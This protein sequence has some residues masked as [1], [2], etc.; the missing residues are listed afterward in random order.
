MKKPQHT[1]AYF[2]FDDN[3]SQMLSDVLAFLTAISTAPGNT[4]VTIAAAA[5]AA[6]KTKITT[7]Q[8]AESNTKTRAI[9][10]AN[11]RDL[12]VEPVVI[13]VQNYVAV[14]QTAV[15]N[16]PNKATALTIIRE[17]G[18]HSKLPVII[19]KNDF[20]VTNNTTTNGMVNIV[21]KAAGEGIHA[22]YEIQE[23]IDGINFTPAKVSP[24][25]R[26]KYA[27]GKAAGT[28]LW[29]RGRI[30]LSE[31]RGGAQLWLTPAVAF[32]FAT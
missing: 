23:S 14:V 17:C 32:I 27:H 1:T 18:L 28:K 11:A 30:S 13:D 2:I 22:C 20:K 26:Y 31:K 7:A 21:F 8:T 12:A 19:N 5:I 10:M 15:N 4:W 29:F 9:G 16:A 24:D 25:S 3:V 6:T